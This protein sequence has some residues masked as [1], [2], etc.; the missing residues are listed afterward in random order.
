MIAERLRPFYD[1]QAKKRKLSTLKQNAA[2][3]QEVAERKTGDARSEAGRAAG[4]NHTYVDQARKVME[5]SPQVA[6]SSDFSHRSIASCICWIS[7]SVSSLPVVRDL[8][9]GSRR[10]GS[11]ARYSSSHRS[12]TDKSNLPL[13]ITGSPA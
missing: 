1:A 6:H 10:S 12:A 11:S 13:S 2:V 9:L 7:S 3:P 4:V 5:A 8:P